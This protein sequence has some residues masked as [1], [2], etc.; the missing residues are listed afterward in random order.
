MGIPATTNPPSA[1]KRAATRRSPRAPK[2]GVVTSSVARSSASARRTS[3]RPNGSGSANREHPVD[4]AP[5]P[6]RDLGC[7][8]HVVLQ[9]AK[10]VA[11]LFQSDL[12][13]VT[14]FGRLTGGDKLLPWIL[15]PQSMQ[16]PRLRRH[17]EAPG[18]RDARAPHHLLG[19]NDLDTPRGPVT[20][21]LGIVH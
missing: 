9:V 1:T 5:R 2:R 20:L 7:D 15:A 21:G 14:A 13:H 8:G 19:G 17:D 18:G 10:R 3:C 6:R 11:Q 16:H 12:L 4:G